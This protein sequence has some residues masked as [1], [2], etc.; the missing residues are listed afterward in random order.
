ML[1]IV[2]NKSKSRDRYSH[3]INGHKVEGNRRRLFFTS[4]KAAKAEL[5]RLEIQIRAEGEDA[6]ALPIA[7]RVLATKAAALLEP[8][9]KN[10]LDAA[11]FYAA[12]LEAQ[13]RDRSVSSVIEEY[14][15]AM[16]NTRFTA[17]Y[18]EDIGQ[19]LGRFGEAFGDRLLGQVT[20]I[21]IE[22]WLY[23]LG[24]APLSVKNYRAVV[25]TFYGFSV[26]RGMSKPIRSTRSINCAGPSDAP[27]IFTNAAELMLQLGHSTTRLIFEHYREI[28]T[29]LGGSGILE[30]SAGESTG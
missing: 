1:R 22:S 28:V 20:P 16:R 30:N 15:A 2:E 14:L 11:R 24:L 13:N 29:P 10:V 12:H 18:L 17:R 3:Y 25:R 26:K 27:E 23:S 21:E 9:G 4:E 8:Y 19:R 6:A 5:K 7:V